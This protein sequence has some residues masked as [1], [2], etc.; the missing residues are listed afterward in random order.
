MIEEI[1][2]C[3]AATTAV[4][5][6]IHSRPMAYLRMEPNGELLF[7]TRAVS[8]KVNEVRRNRHINLNFS[9]AGRNLYVSISGEAR[10]V[11]DRNRIAE[12]FTHIM[13][14]WFPGGADDPTL[15]LLVVDPYAA[16]YWEGPAGLT[17]LFRTAKS[18]ITGEPAD[19]GE[20]ELMEL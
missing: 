13:K 7:F 14:Q 4:D 12:L 19:L 11:N 17:L 16:E 18:M 9:D 1:A 5:G 8:T 10:V 6:T 2:V 20:H 3:M 15:R